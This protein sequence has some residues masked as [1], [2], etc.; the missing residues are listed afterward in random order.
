MVTQ[1]L[2]QQRKRL[3]YGKFRQRD[4]RVE[5]NRCDEVW[6]CMQSDRM[7]FLKRVLWSI[8]AFVAA[9]WLGATIWAYWPHDDELPAATLATAADRFVQVDGLS[10]RYREWGTKQVEADSLVLIHGFGNS[11]QSFR[12]LAPLLAQTHHVIA[13]DM[14][15]YG[16]SDK[17]VNYDY[18]SGPQ[19]NTLIRAA[20]QLGL[21]RIIYV[22]HSLGGAVALQAVVYDERATGLVLLNPGIIS[23]GVPKIVQVRLPPLPRM[24]AKLFASREFRG[25]FLKNSYV[26]PQVV[27][28]QVI[29]EVM[30]AARTEGYMTGTTALMA[31]YRE[32]EEVRLARK[33]TVP[34]LIPWGSQDRNKPPGEAE[35][36]QALLPRSQLIK[37]DNAGHYVHEEAAPGVAAAIIEWLNQRTPAHAKYQQPRKPTSE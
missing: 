21:D 30:L 31:Q 1:R 24:S 5:Q 16:L 14:I 18:H 28:E 6:N 2:F 3:E 9:L 33:V 37:F 36:L 29:D 22:G 7:R 8:V 23:T 17:P 20:H 11:L 35:Q 19:A 10:L 4:H 32:G 34:T 25:R 15:G 27:T 13:I 12:E 26:N